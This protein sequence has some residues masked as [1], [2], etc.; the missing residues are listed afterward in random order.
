MER[1]WREWREGKK[2]WSKRNKNKRRWKH[3]T[4]RRII[5]FRSRIRKV[6]DIERHFTRDTCP[7]KPRMR[8]V[9]LCK[10]SHNG[11]NDTESNIQQISF[12]YTQDIEM[13]EKFHTLIIRAWNEFWVSLVRNSYTMKIY[14][15]NRLG[16]LRKN[17]SSAI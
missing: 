3:V 9:L 13:Y 16:I 14:S 5:K 2:R 17:A 10:V 6:K 11:N 15:E 4:L 8:R 12:L 1:N 7:E